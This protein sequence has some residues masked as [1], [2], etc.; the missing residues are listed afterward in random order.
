MDRQLLLAQLDE[1]YEDMCKAGLD[2][3]AD[4][5]LTNNNASEDDSGEEGF[6]KT[7]SNEDIQN[8]I[9]EMKR[10]MSLLAGDS[11]QAI[12]F[13]IESGVYDASSAYCQ[14][15]LDAAHIIAQEY[16]LDLTDF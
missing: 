8:A 3:N 7:M 1:I 4:D 5:I 13:Q 9:N 11:A 2:A 12:L 15:F 16:G 10:A 14:G 6:M